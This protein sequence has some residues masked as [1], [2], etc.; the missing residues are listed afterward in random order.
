MSKLL[1][2]ISKRL[3]RRPVL[4]YQLMKRKGR[5]WELIEKFEAA[6]LPHP[7]ELDLVPGRYH[8]RRVF[9]DGTFDIPWKHTEPGKAGEEA[10]KR[11]V[12]IA[13][14][15]K[16]FRELAEALKS[17]RESSAALNLTTVGPRPE[18]TS[19]EAVEE[20]NYAD[21]LFRGWIGYRAEK[22]TRNRPDYG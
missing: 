7:E 6:D 15:M 13:E 22:S 14:A 3:K 8:I 20:V 21:R 4:K 16:G 18:T 17:F 1:R 11:A 19:V 5:T 10:P 12:D 9:E 2:R